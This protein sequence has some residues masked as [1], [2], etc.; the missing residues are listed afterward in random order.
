MAQGA[1]MSNWQGGIRA[2]AFVAGGLLK[3][4]APRM[5]GRKL[6]G[7]VHICD[8]YHLRYRVFELLEMTWVYPTILKCPELGPDI[9]LTEQVPITSV[10]QLGSKAK[11]MLWPSSTILLA[12]ETEHTT[13]TAAAFSFVVP[14]TPFT[15][16]FVDRP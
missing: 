3:R 15:D 9:Y 10:F 14:S 16:K 2:N 12:G 8:W 6:S 11:V 1:K 13:T 7:F 4:L 5:L